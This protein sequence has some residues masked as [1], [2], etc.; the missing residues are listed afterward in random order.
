MHWT[1]PVVAAI[2]ICTLS[3]SIGVIAN[4]A[5]AQDAHPA[6]AQSSRQASQSI[7]SQWWRHAVIY[8]VYPRS[9]QD[10]NGDG[11]GDLKGIIER[12]DYLQKLGVDAI[13]L[14]PVYPS[15]NFDVG[16]DVSD[17]RDIN[18]EYGTMADF[19][20]LMA[21]AT[22]R[23]IRV[24]MD[25]VMNHTSDMNAWFVQSRSSRTDPYRDWYVWHD[26]KGE[27]ATDPGRPPNNWG[28]FSHPSWTWDE[29]TRQY[30]YHAYSAD[31]PDLNWYNPA[32]HEEFKDILGYWLKQGVAG[33]RFDAVAALYEDPHFTDEEP[34]VDR[35][36]KP[37]L[38]R[39]GNP[40]H[41]RTK[42]SDLPAVHTV[43][44]EMRA[45]IDSF[46][47][48]AFPGSR[49]MI[50]EV[51]PHNNTD[52]LGW[53]GSRAKPEFQLPMD[54]QV[55]FIDKLDVASFRQKLTEAETGIDG[56]VPLIVFDNHDRPRL[57]A[58]FGDGI[59]DVAIQ[60][61]LSTILFASGGASLMYYGDEIGMKTTP[62]TRVEDVK[63]RMAGVAGWPRFK[64][65]DG[66][67]TPM[68]WDAGKN[69]GFSAGSP[70]LPVP[71][72]AATINVA[73]EESDPDSLLAWYRSLIRLKKSVP[74][75][76]SGAN[77]MLDT[78]NTK[79]LSWKREIAGR[80]PVIVAVNFTADPQTVD[81]AGPGQHDG[82]MTTLL[83][84]PGATD[85]AALKSISL[86]PYGVYIGELK[87]TKR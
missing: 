58:R 80:A 70:W 52:L 73:A 50:G 22:K 37:I 35:N 62:P 69:A 27:T 84:S 33:F 56:N 75:L 77:V 43:I 45:R 26:G 18:P 82:P 19:D 57:D 72:S 25:M 78:E 13:W 47:S 30:Y 44:Q 87:L 60:R 41:E 10:T 11:I 12:L 34:T 86:G 31:Q 68:Q 40:M 79:V 61:V 21:E 32:V 36:G 39:S 16:Y 59:H 1:K 55:G 71:P 3:L 2:A 54:M 85:P 76:E 29:A 49:V 20:R 7:G 5:V 81:L 38:D 28:F 9:F 64:G 67:R 6:T 24:I 65:R 42:T 4:A 46:D 74:A 8:Q 51:F 14:S 15:P 83:K 23:H 66:E 63:D 17:Y 48:S 53:Y